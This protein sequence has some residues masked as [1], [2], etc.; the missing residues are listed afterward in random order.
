MKGLISYI[1]RKKT[2]LEQNTTVKISVLALK[3]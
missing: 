2:K 1:D 3:G